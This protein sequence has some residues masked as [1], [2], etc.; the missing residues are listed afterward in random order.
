MRACV[1]AHL[2]GQAEDLLHQLLGL[3]GLL[4]EQLDD[5]GQQGELHLHTEGRKELPSAGVKFRE[6]ML[7]ASRT[8]EAKSLLVLLQ[9]YSPAGL[10]LMGGCCWIATGPIE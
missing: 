5:G 8:S 3:G 4:E 2:R 6:N 9:I 1:H 10:A 7:L